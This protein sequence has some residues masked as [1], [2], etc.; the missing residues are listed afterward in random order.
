[1]YSYLYYEALLLDEKIRF[2]IV[3]LHFLKKKRSVSICRSLFIIIQERYI[4]ALGSTFKFTYLF[5]L[6][7]F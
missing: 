2:I 3:T 1:M 7:L 5:C 4:V 6:F